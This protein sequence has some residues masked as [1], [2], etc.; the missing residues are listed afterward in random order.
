[1]MRCLPNLCFT[2]IGLAACSG[3]GGFAYRHSFRGRQ[4]EEETRAATLDVFRSKRAGVRFD[5][6]TGNGQAHPHSFRFCGKEMIEDFLRP[7]GGQTGPEI[8][9]AD[10]RTLSL[11]RTCTNSDAAL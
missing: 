8:A 4:A 5:N 2:S 3:L 1:M 10:F 9:H 6:R 11:K 7:V